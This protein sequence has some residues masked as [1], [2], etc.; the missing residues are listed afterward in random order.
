[1]AK[2]PAMIRHYLRIG[3]RNF[4]KHKTSSAINAVGL[5][6]AVGCSLFVFLFIEFF[7]TIDEY[8]ENGA[9]IFVIN[10]EVLIDDGIQLYSGTP[11]PLISLLKNQS[12]EITR[13]SRLK[14]ALAYVRYEE[15]VFEENIRF[16]DP[17]FLQMFSFPLKWGVVQSLKE[18]NSIILSEN[19]SEKYFGDQNPLGEALSIKFVIDNEEVIEPFVIRGVADE[20]MRNSSF[21][22]RFIINYDQQ[23]KLGFDRLSD[24][25]KENDATFIELRNPDNL[26]AVSTLLAGYTALQNAAVDEYEVNGYQLTPFLKASRQGQQVKGNIFTSPGVEGFIVLSILATI[27][28]SLAC[29]NYMNIA[30]ASA[31]YRLK[32]IGIR[33]VMGGARKQLIFQF[34]VENVIICSTALVLGLVWTQLFFLPGFQALVPNPL[35][36]N[37]SDYRL[38][39]FLGAVLLVTVIGGAG[40]PALYISGFQ[41]VSILKDKIRFGGKSLFRRVL[42]GFQYLFSFVAIIA[43]IVLI[44]N[45]NYQ[46]TLDWGYDKDAVIG[47]KINGGVAYERLKPEIENLPGILQVAGT[48][49]RIGSGNEEVTFDYMESPYTTDQL[50]VGWDYLETLGLHFTAGRTFDRQRASDADQSIIVNQTLVDEMSWEEPIGKILTLGNTDFNVVGV[51]QDFHYRPFWVEIEP[52]VIRLSSQDDY[53]YLTARVQPDRMLEVGELMEASWYRVFPNDP[54][55]FFYQDSVFDNAFREFDMVTAIIT[56]AG[57]IAILLALIGLFGLSSLRIKAKLKEISIRK[58]L[59]GD[60]KH[61]SLV[62]NKEFALLL[63]AASALAVPLSFFAVRAL[64][65]TVTKYPMPMTPWPFMIALTMLITLSIAAVGGHVYRAVL[66]NPSDIL[67]TE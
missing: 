19:M 47:V 59:G 54:Y 25:S 63:F 16:V 23:E 8:H 11:E 53:K 52:L 37:L 55:D 26:G 35:A 40:Y 3:F 57:S 21:R 13:A 10:Q 50:R 65:E 42:L 12:A 33:K 7:L 18:P 62:L 44:Q 36:L 31:A 15:N 66:T 64:L 61:L 67:R 9:S 38:W 20:F 58:V 46:R 28:M 5:S 29:I 45:N 32:E 48:S 2:S 6:L 49:N 41:P 51:V 27:I 24:W 43:A 17:D 56:T 39:T 22:F 30:V 60:W 1:M 34:L 14:D 4:L